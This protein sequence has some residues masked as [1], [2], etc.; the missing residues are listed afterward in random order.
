LVGNS[1]G[2]VLILVGHGD[3][4]FRPFEPV[5]AAVALAVAD[6]TGDGVLDYVFADQS[7]NEV[8]VVYG[9]LS[10]NATDTTVVGDQTTGVL[11]P[12]AVLLHDMNGDGIPDLVVANSGGNN[13]LVYPGL[14]NGQ[15]GPP[16]GGTEGFAV[17]TD[18]TGL[19]VANLN[20][21]ADL[22]VADTGSN[23]VSVLLGK[24]TGTNWTMIP[25]ARVQTDA[26]PVAVAVGN[27][28]G[29]GKTALA[30]A[31][32]GANDVQVFPSAGS[33]FFSNEPAATY[34]VGQDP[35]ALFLGNFNGQGLGLATL[36]AGSND[37]T[38]IS[39]AGSSNLSI[40]AFNTGGDSPTSGFAGDFEG[41]GL[42]DLVVGNN[43]DGRLA[44]LLGNSEGL[45]LSQSLV[46]PSVPSP[47]DMSF[48][49]VADGVLSFYVSTAGRD[50]ALELSFDLSSSAA[51]I[52]P[53]TAPSLSLSA[54]PGV[55]TFEVARL[56]EVTGSAFDLIAS[57]VTLTILPEN[58]ESQQQS[59]G[60]GALLASFS[61]GGTTG[62]GQSLNQG[63]GPEG[64]RSEDT[65][66]ANAEVASGPASASLPVDRLAPW[67]RVSVGLDETWRELIDRLIGRERMTES[68]AAQSRPRS[69]APQSPG[70][71]TAP[72][73][74][75][76]PDLNS[77]TNSPKR[78]PIERG[79]PGGTQGARAKMPVTYHELSLNVFT[80]TNT[81]DEA[82]EEPGPPTSRRQVAAGLSIV[83]ANGGPHRDSSQVAGAI[84]VLSM[85]WERA[86]ATLSGRRVWSR[87]RTPSD[88]FRWTSNDAVPQNRDSRVRRS[89]RFAL[90]PTRH[91]PAFGQTAIRCPPSPLR[92][93][94]RL[95]YRSIDS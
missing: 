7:L 4:T 21:Q 93:P 16:I 49:G 69:V 59:E 78:S 70:N 5:K 85:Q 26:G 50:S 75:S 36:N 57:L 25:G 86:I 77:P 55:M 22:L 61:L 72:S 28:L 24:G 45:S 32:S 46:N 81:V 83:A 68:G 6:L 73:L 58:L 2:D 88:R 71:S 15:F 79:G 80:I 44:L 66:S 94:P 42:T 8:S 74:S 13:V 89:N 39:G 23:E 14:G 19:T 67:A 30:V 34:P 27:V 17:G 20:G 40:R 1:Y 52:G 33:G 11:A 90:S 95:V 31:N 10:S 76:P 60:G 92:I 47:T 54:A 56:G 3:G 48:G 82:T 35:A 18:P 51:I 9:S 62:L 53:G 29:N 43:G 65:Q 91:G 37:G 84:L 38:L 63:K 12:G 87:R 41:N 64:G